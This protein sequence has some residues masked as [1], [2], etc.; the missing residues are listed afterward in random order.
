MT[1]IADSSF[2]YAFYNAGDPSHQDAEKF[3]AQNRE[4][5]L[6][7][8]VALPEVCYLITRDMG[9][10]YIRTFLEYFA[11]LGASFFAYRG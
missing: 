4:Q 10:R 5:F 7:P 9:H 11:Q 1:L 2:V 8:N 6:V 3:V